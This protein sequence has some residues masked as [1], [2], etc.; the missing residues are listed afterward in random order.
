MAETLN[1]FEEAAPNQEYEAEM[2]AKGEALE[3]ANNPDRPEWLPEK[4]ESAEAMAQAYADLERKLGSSSKDSTEEVQTE[5]DDEPE[6]NAEAEASD[7]AQALD[8]VGLDF[9]TF[10]Q[11]YT[12]TGGLS[13]EAYDSLAEKGFNRELVDTWIAGQE[14]IAQQQ[15]GKIF[16]MVGGQDSYAEMVQWAAENLSE[17]EIDAYNTN[18]ESGD[19]SLANFAVQGLAA[20]Y[21]SEVGSEPKLVQGDAASSSSGAFQSVA[22]LTS[23]MR[24]PRYGKDPAYRNAV[25]EK[26]SRSN[27]F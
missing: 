19:M 23:A 10:Q 25:A 12:E 24:D 2:L 6:L 18:V 5:T 26:L 21:R 11:E 27:V 17:S 3:T 9:D 8:N 7:V 20:R 22:E 4:F 1:T 15:T 16:D 13:D 14:A